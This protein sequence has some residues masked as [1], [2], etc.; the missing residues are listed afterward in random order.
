MSE[1]SVFTSHKSDATRKNRIE[2]RKRG[3]EETSPLVQQDAS[4]SDFPRCP[5][6]VKLPIDKRRVFPPVVRFNEDGW[7]KTRG[8]ETRGSVGVVA[9]R[10]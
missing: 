4:F 5:T 8:G 3:K 2:E 1:K 6:I 9:R 7:L 10:N